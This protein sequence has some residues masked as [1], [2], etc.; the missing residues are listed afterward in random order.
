M[1]TAKLSPLERDEAATKEDQALR[2]MNWH[3]EISTIQFH[4][5][6][7]TL[8][9][10]VV[11]VAGVA[12]NFQHAVCVGKNPSMPSKS[13]QPQSLCHLCMNFAF[14]VHWFPVKNF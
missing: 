13:Q 11:F 2:W 14:L 3:H 6:M 10:V 7:I 4:L 1:G 5:W 9:V 8:H 12:V